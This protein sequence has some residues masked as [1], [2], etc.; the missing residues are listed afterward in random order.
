MENWFLYF[1]VNLLS[2]PWTFAQGIK[3][4]SRR[5]ITNLSELFLMSLELFVIAFVL[6]SAQRIDQGSVF[7]EMPDDSSAIV[8]IQW[9]II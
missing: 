4:L 7:I 1:L 6:I 5:L 8:L 2:L 9:D 3:S